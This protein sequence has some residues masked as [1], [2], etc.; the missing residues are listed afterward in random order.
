VQRRRQAWAGR[1]R[2]MRELAH[3]LVCLDETSVRTGLTRLHGRCPRGERLYGS[4]PFGRWHS[5]AFVAGRTCDE[6]IAPWI[7]SGARN[8]N[9]FD[10]YVDTQLAPVLDPGTVVI[11]DNLS[12]HRS[13]PAAAS[14]KARGGWSALGGNRPPDGFLVPRTPAALQP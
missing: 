6:M 9:A 5:Q 3:R 13:P 10:T 4:A 14:L 11:L 2:W 8:G 12:T 7:I 1:P